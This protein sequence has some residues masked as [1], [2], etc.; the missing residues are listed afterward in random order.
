MRK[1]PGFQSGLINPRVL[2]AF[3]LCSVG[4]LL[5][6]LSFAA[7]P[8]V[9]MSG[10]AT[11][12][13]SYSFF[14]GKNVD[15]LHGGKAG[16]AS[17]PLDPAS[18][19]SWTTVTSP[20]ATA[21][22]SNVLLGMTCVSASDCWAV[23]Y[24]GGSRY[25]EQTLIEHWNGS[26]WAIVTSPPNGFFDNRRLYSITCVSA[27]D[28]WAVG[29]SYIGST[30]P[31]VYQTLVEHWN[32]SSWAI[33]ASPNSSA[34]HSNALYGVT[35]TS[36]SNCWTVGA[37][38][39][40]A[41][42]PQTLIEQW[43]GASWTIVPSP[44]TSPTK[45]NLLSGVTCT[46]ASECWAVGYYSNSSGYYQTLIEQWS[47]TSWSIVTSPNTSPTEYNLL[48]GVTCTS[49]SECWA[50][51]YYNSASGAFQTL[52]EQWNGTSWAIVASPNTSPT[53]NNILLGLTCKSAS[54]CWA[55]GY[56]GNGIGFA[57]LTLIEQWNG[58]SWTI[59]ASPNSGTQ[60]NKLYGV[61]CAA[62]S[63]CWAA[64]YYYENG[65]GLNQT[66]IEQWNGAS[67]T[68][69][70]SPNAGAR[71]PNFLNGV[72]CV[73]ASECWAV[74]YAYEGGPSPYYYQTL[75]E[76][77]DGKSWAIVTSPNASATW[78][79]VLDSV[80]CTSASD[81]WAVGYAYDPTK[82]PYQY[83]TFTEHW[84]GTSWAIVGSPNTG[85][86][87]NVLNDVTCTSASNCW[88][89]GYSFDSTTGY[90]HTLVERWNGTSWAI[91]TSPNTL[92][93]EDNFLY[94]VTCSSAT[95]CW[96]VGYSSDPTG[97]VDQ[98]LIE[99]WNGTTWSI[100]TSPN[101]S[102]IANNSLTDVTCVSASD[103]WAVGHSNTGNP[104]QS[105]IDQTL[106]ERW[107]GT[108]WTIVGSPNSSPT[109]GNV[110]DGVTCT[111]DSNCWAVGSSYDSTT[112]FDHTLIE[113][114]NGTSWAIVTS[115]H[116][117]LNNMLSGVTCVSGSD[118]WAVGSEFQQTLIEKFAIPVQLTSVVSELTH[119]SAGTFDINLPLTGNPGVECRGGH[120]NGDYKLLFT[121]P[122]PLTSVGGASV[123]SGAGLVS[124]SAIDPS[125]PHNYLVN[126]SR[127][128]NAQTITV[129]LTNV[130]D[131]AG[132][133]SSTH[134]G[135]MGILL[136]DV[137][138]NR[139]VSN[140]DVASV[141][142]QVGGAVDS[143]NFRADVNANGIISNTDVSTTKAQVGTALP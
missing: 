43:N 121:F 51:G 128:T 28:C 139:V 45:Y 113:R 68:I 72:T 84:N 12:L 80:T 37:Y 75:I 69:V 41:G 15:M 25:P 23:G 53:Q 108:S 134:S 76:R 100:V 138:A 95:N 82:L 60:T 30:T 92:P 35:C 13:P 20:N 112:G 98:T 101:T 125:D 24:S 78:S 6:M 124:S 96:A 50:V 94:G 1:N 117:T 42:A 59:V 90:N 40:T 115:P 119:G 47:G 132:N 123:A 89:V 106:I 126:L 97:N 46:S 32:G 26:S 22:E 87:V 70:T 8:P 67:W 107:N 19:G 55:V 54:E 140:T 130:T 133:F 14:V 64:S 4:V 33:V 104:T 31:T 63:A 93:V 66:L 7:N 2:F 129:S 17:A 143:S 114:W 56:Y 88:A 111:S 110:L 83:Q 62:E 49:A 85:S 21:P 91:V 142:T 52:I 79:N 127:V 103:C 16:Y 99:Q 109:E 86:Q 11:E 81:C 10:S 5:A 71:E 44:N 73:S 102:P 135:S 58:T 77:W 29:Y 39:N 48:S 141:K 118:C 74:G 136:G 18:T 36:A 34:T 137:N 131:S 116:P 9:T 105:G 120:A 27:V 61:T 57:D 3:A 38:V 65:S 122:N